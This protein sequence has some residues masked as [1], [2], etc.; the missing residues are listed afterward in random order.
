MDRQNY[1]DLVAVAGRESAS[2]IRLFRDFDPVDG[3]RDV[4]D[5]YYGGSDGFTRVFEIVDRTNR[6][7]LAHICKQHDLP[8]SD[9]SIES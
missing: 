9:G 6:A 2:N 4:P 7:V 8:C 3:D 1:A 5:P